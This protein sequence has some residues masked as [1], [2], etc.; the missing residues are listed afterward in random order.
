MLL[1]SA[2][3]TPWVK[4][5][6]YSSCY[7]G[8][9]RQEEIRFLQGTQLVPTKARVQAAL[10]NSKVFA[11]THYIIKHYSFQDCKCRFL[12]YSFSHHILTVCVE[13]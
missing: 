5:S 10:P 1:F 4:S 2:V 6:Y 11:L 9:L 12:G 7:D 8:I 3:A 13:L